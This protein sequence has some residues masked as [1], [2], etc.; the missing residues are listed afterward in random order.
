[1]PYSIRPVGNHGSG[2]LILEAPF[3]Y[4]LETLADFADQGSFLRLKVAAPALP[5]NDDEYVTVWARDFPVPKPSLPRWLREDLALLKRDAKRGPRGHAYADAQRLGLYSHKS[6]LGRVEKIR[7]LRPEDLE[8]LPQPYPQQESWDRTAWV[9]YDPAYLA[10][11]AEKQR[12]DSNDR[13]LG[14]ALRRAG[15]RV[16]WLTLAR[17]AFVSAD[18]YDTLSAERSR[19][20]PYPTSIDLFHPSEGRIVVYVLPHGKIATIK[21]DERTLLCS[22]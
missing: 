21:F 14:P 22:D 2:E 16:Q 12:F 5:D 15:S 11:L 3:D 9:P 6:T 8:L 13:W 17:A 7:Y 4:F 18:E 19:K 10:E 20:R 1:M